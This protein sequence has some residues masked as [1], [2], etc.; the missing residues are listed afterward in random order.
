LGKLSHSIIVSVFDWMYEDAGAEVDFDL[1]I[2]RF[3]VV[4]LSVRAA[5]AA[6]F[7]RPALFDYATPALMFL[8]AAVSL[9]LATGPSRPMVRIAK[10][11]IV[12]SIPSDPITWLK[13]IG[14]VATGIGSILLAWRAREILKWV[15][16]CLV[17]HEQSLSELRKLASGQ[18]QT[19]AI[20]EGVTKH[21]LDIQSKLGFCLLI[22][23]FL[24]LAAG[25]LCNA[26]TYLLVSH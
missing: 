9:M 6:G 23:G 4:W 21:L 13:L 8:F 10:E 3:Q 25:M 24:L 26:A 2:G 16:Y 15:V 22:L 19:D 1:G 20:V 7:R 14:A 11:Q 5:I 17:A 18:P 12:M